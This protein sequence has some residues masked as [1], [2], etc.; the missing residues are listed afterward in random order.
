MNLIQKKL[1]SVIIFSL[2]FHCTYAQPDGCKLDSSVV[3][4]N[5]GL[6]SCKSELKAVLFLNGTYLEPKKETYTYKISM[7]PCKMSFYIDAE[8]SAD[9]K[10]RVKKASA[11]LLREKKMI[12]SPVTTTTIPLGYIKEKALP[13]DEIE[14][15]IMEIIA[16]DMKGRIKKV[17]CKSTKIFIKLL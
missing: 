3:Q 17:P 4:L 5:K 13:G 12:D 11:V 16:M 6:D 14:V 8:F 9:I 15:E 10:Y 1:T 2:S 7:I